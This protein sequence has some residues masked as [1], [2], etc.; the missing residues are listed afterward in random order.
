MLQ[1][2]GWH[3]LLRGPGDSLR[4]STLPILILYRRRPRTPIGCRW[5]RVPDSVDG[6]MPGERDRLNP[7]Q[8]TRLQPVF[9]RVSPAVSTAGW[10]RRAV[11]SQGPSAVMTGRGKGSSLNSRGGERGHRSSV[12]NLGFP[13]KVADLWS[14]GLPIYVT[15]FLGPVT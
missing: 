9:R 10:K 15:G 13:F 14:V 2:G 5:K 4:R 12:E 6:E 3:D 1:R 11:E 8:A 7:L